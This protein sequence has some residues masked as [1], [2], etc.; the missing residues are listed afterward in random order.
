MD[1]N[2][3]EMVFNQLEVGDRFMYPGNTKDE[4]RVVFKSDSAIHYS[5]GDLVFIILPEYISWG[6]FVTKLD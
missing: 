3:T 1:L 5:I 4:C 2:D 6:S